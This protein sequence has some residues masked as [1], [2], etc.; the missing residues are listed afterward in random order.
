MNIFPC[1]P[2]L[3][4][5]RSS[6]NIMYRMSCFERTTR[7][8]DD[9]VNKAT[10]KTRRRG[11]STSTETTAALESRKGSIR[12]IKKKRY[13]FGALYLLAAYFISF[14]QR[15]PSGTYKKG[16]PLVVVDEWVGGIGV[17]NKD[18]VVLSL[19]WS[20][21]CSSWLG[22]AIFRNEKGI[23][24]SVSLYICS[25]LS[26]RPERIC[27]GPHTCRRYCHTHLQLWPGNGKW[28][29]EICTRLSVLDIYFFWAEISLNTRLNFYGAI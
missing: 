9:I 25:V 7:D 18:A 11:A 22:I 14:L 20:W 10:T 28:T 27:T 12:M 17:Y 23:R 15:L 29:K 4:E 13:N 2:F 6:D 26:E 3:A 5:R 8:Y 19:L 21:Q 16:A 24:M 1:S